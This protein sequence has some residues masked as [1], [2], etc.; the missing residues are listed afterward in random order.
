ML[1]PFHFECLR[2]W[3]H[4]AQEIKDLSHWRDMAF[5]EMIKAGLLGLVDRGHPKEFRAMKL[6]DLEKIW[7]CWGYMLSLATFVFALEL[8]CFWR[9]KIWSKI[10]NI[11]SLKK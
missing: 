2:S 6:K 11:F 1:P 8:I 7:R 4:S 10:R 5:T 3:Q 9:Q